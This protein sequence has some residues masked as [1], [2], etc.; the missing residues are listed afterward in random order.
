[1]RYAHASDRPKSDPVRLLWWKEGEYA[2]SLLIIFAVA[3]AQ[4]RLVTYN[5]HP[6]SYYLSDVNGFVSKL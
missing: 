4:P 5:G 6:A 1:M 2:P 3:M